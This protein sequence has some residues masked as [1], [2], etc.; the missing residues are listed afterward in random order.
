MGLRGSIYRFDCVL[1]DLEEII[2][3]TTNLI[4]VVRI[5]PWTDTG[6]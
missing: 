3:F 5:T 2:R 4:I 1:L 6:Y